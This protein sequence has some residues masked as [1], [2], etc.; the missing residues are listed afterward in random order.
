MRGDAQI[1]GSALEARPVLQPPPHT[2]TRG[3]LSQ[4]GQRSH[5]GTRCSVSASTSI[6]GAIKRV[7]TD[8]VS[9][10]VIR[11]GSNEPIEIEVRAN[12]EPRA[13]GRAE[14]VLRAG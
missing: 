1:L 14:E 5:L 9:G 11:D 6:R 12:G 3:L 8:G 2:D 7:T 4:F 13:L 10:L